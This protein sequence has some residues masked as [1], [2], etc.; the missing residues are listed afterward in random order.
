M[1]A[2]MLRDKVRSYLGTTT[3]IDH[4]SPLFSLQYDGQNWS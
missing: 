4:K 2:I 3:G 1:L